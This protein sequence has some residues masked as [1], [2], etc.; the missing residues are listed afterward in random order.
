MQAISNFEGLDARVQMAV[1]TVDSNLINTCS[2]DCLEA[3]S[4]TYCNVEAPMDC[5]L[6]TL[7]R[8]SA[9]GFLK[10]SR[11]GT[12]YVPCSVH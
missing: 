7:H 2:T 9:T 11:L 12:S 10:T 6:R 1:T 4:K 8:L 3:V 5:L